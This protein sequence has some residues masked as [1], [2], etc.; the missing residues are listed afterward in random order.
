MKKETFT[1]PGTGLLETSLKCLF[2]AIMAIFAQLQSISAQQQCPLVCDDLVQ[3]SLDE[4][5][6]AVITPDM[7]LE[8][9]GDGCNYRVVVYDLNNFPLAD[10]TVRS[11]HI[12]KT[13]TVA[14]FLGNNSCWG[15]IHV[16]DKL[17]PII[18]CP[19]PDTVFCNLADYEFAEPVVTDNCTGV[20]RHEISDVTV[21][22]PCDSV[23]AGRRTISYY[24]TD[25]YGNRSDT[26]AQVIYFSKIDP[27]VDVIWPRDTIFDCLVM[28]S[29]PPP[30]VTGVPTAGGQPVYPSWGV[31]KIALTY[32][33]QVIPV[34]PKSFKV[35]RK[36]TYID[37]CRPS[38]ENIYYHFQIIKVVDEKG[39]VIACPAPVTVS[40]DVW[41]CTGT[42]ILPP[43]T[44]LEECSNV[45]FQAAYKPFVQG[46]SNGWEGTSTDLV[47]RLGNGL[48]SIS[49]LPLGKVWVV[50]RA[51][52]ECGNITDCATLVTIAD[53]VPPVAV[54]DQ[55]TVVTL[56]IDGTAKIFAE[57]FDD[58]SHDNC[59]IDRFEVRRM[60]LGF[61]CDT[62]SGRQYAPFVY[63]C[64]ED[65]GKT[66][67][68][69]MRVWDIHGN[70][71]TCMVE[72]EVQDKL[73]PV[74]VCPPDITISCEY[75]FTD[76]N[77]FGTVR[78][79]YADRKPIT[80][81]DPKVRFSGPA[82]DG[83]AY[84]GCGVTVKETVTYDLVCGQGRILRRFEATDPGGLRSFCTQTIRITD[85]TPDNVSVVWPDDF[86][87]NTV[88]AT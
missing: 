78:T 31:C 53:L 64:C 54:C 20:H 40:T 82:I 86:L 14:V 48:F 49:G 32:E 72:V 28:D 5:C 65:L 70:S 68:V 58:R 17:P 69:N 52:D 61:P 7:I 42:V 2:L 51:T 75:D 44:V 43:P 12:G 16:E 3:V 4:N 6:I 83:Y 60:D 76:L 85:F 67:M 84:D 1:M 80:I 35:I 45:T 56:T 39:P 10:A 50:F 15:S 38:G 41:T 62:L 59:G 19:L 37:W 25:D 77:V 63:F 47:T 88:C 18:E 46:G 81:S 8:E 22:Y 21:K 9:P 26:C 74:I 55:K 57:T 71:N 36:W 33:D 73:A 87:S 66:L 23:L 11:R 27:L 34:C 29:V 30:S 24:Y 13:L 79:N